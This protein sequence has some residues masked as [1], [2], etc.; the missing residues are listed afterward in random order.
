MI[1]MTTTINQRALATG[2]GLAICF[3]A[4]SFR[5]VHLQVTQ[6]DHY[7]SIAA[8]RNIHVEPVY[9]RRGAILDVNGAVLAQNE[10]VKTVVADAQLIND[11][12]KLAETLAKPLEMSKAAI[13][14]KLAKQVK[15]KVSGEMV[16]CRYI[17]LRK[18]LSEEKAIEI[19]KLVADCKGRKIVQ[20]LDAIYYK[21]DFVRVYP[22]GT[23]LCHVIG[24]TNDAGVGMN[25]I[26]SSMNE[27]L[28]CVNGERNVERAR[29]GRELVLYRG[30][31]REPR[32]GGN[33]RL[34]IDLN[35]Q[36]I[37]ESELDQAV[38]QLRPK[39][40]SVVMMNP[41]TGE[42]MAMA[43]RPNFD[44][45]AVPKYE[46]DKTKS[47]ANQKLNPTRNIAVSDQLEP[48]STFKI[49]P[50][51]AALSEKIV[52]LDTEIGTENGY[53]QWCKLKD[54]HAHPYL[55]VRNVLV[56]SSNI[57]AAKIGIQLGEQKLYEYARKFGF[58]K[59]TNVGLPA[60]FGGTVN[61]PEVWD[62][63]TITRM[64]MGQSVAATPLQIANSMCT[65][66]K[67]GTLMTPQIVRDFV[68]DGATVPFEPQAK[69]RAVSQKAT[70]QVR[71]ALMDVVGPKGTALE[72]AVPGFKVAGKTG[73]AQK[74]D[75]SGHIARDRYVVSF[76][77]FLPAM[78]PAF[79]LFVIFD[80]PQV[81][82]ESY[83]GGKVA[84]PVFSRIAG[85][86]ARYLNL[87][88][89][90]P[91]V[92]PGSKLTKEDSKSRSRGN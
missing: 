7:E 55:S 59:P 32:D 15:S 84:G 66:A 67:G 74:K 6:H 87:Q 1:A 82:H 4:F 51:S 35:L 8:S 27:R 12:D 60:E 53:W 28:Q 3:T 20:S 36:Q 2:I 38:R 23:T 5:L 90:E 43:N 40:A 64:P 42:I 80:E 89:T 78:D 62:K 79:V 25:G 48:G 88:P 24:Y 73:T 81:N 17:L 46:E 83:Y 71:E 72:A 70:E 33:V 22:N 91:V 58:G 44:P 92:L 86:A 57:G 76:S 11:F 85:R 21:Q 61:P 10:P 16:P 49:V 29:D 54:T 39:W 26:E 14:E 13:L 65:I 18:D 75:E 45:N 9:A 69:W 30:Q 19:S 52:S 77:G 50:V 31:D 63:L 56:K 68:N 47:K 37:V 34:T 41:K